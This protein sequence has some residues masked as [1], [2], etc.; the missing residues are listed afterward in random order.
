MLTGV[1]GRKETRR[2]SEVC[3]FSSI[4][5]VRKVCLDLGLD[6]VSPFYTVT[7]DKFGRVPGAQTLENVGTFSN[8]SSLEVY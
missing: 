5:E 8:F 4:Y 2:L 3:V 6:W 7:T 1:E